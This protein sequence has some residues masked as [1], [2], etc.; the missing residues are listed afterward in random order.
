VWGPAA[1]HAIRYERIRNLA[2]QARPDASP[3]GIALTSLSILVMP[4][5][6]GVD[7]GAHSKA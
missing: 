6:A 1:R 2:G 3:A 7:L 5:L 4:W